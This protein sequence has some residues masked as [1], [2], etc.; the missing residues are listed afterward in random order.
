VSVAAHDGYGF[1]LEGAH[2]AVPCVGCH[3]DMKRPPLSASLVGTAPRG[4]RIGFTRATRA[5]TEC[6]A[7][8]HDGQFAAR[9]AKGGC[10]SCHGVEAFRPAAGF[11]HERDTP[12]S[13]RGAHAK[14]E[15][16]TC[17]TATRLVGDGRIVV[18]APLSGKC[19][20]CHTAER[21]AS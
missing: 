15:C 5:C 11:D 13:L 18:Y 14:V 6:H 1:P 4:T 16:T 10:E 9:V 17:H 3:D 21:K 12:F 20:S 8:A 7:D 2:R 19:E